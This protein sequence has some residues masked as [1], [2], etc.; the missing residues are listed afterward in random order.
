M[1]DFI[2]SITL[3]SSCNICVIAAGVHKS[4]EEVF[5]LKQSHV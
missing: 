1:F 3:S 5:L 2:S 4:A